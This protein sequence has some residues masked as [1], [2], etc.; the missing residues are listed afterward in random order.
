MAERHYP[1]VNHA[2]SCWNLSNHFTHYC[3]SLKKNMMKIDHNFGGFSHLL[4]GYFIE[5]FCSTA[6][7]LVSDDNTRKQLARLILALDYTYSRVL[8]MS[9]VHILGKPLFFRAIPTYGE[10]PYSMINTK[11]L[12][13]TEKC[14]AVPGRKFR[15]S[16]TKCLATNY[17][18]TISRWVIKGGIYYTKR[19]ASYTVMHN[20]TSNL[21]VFLNH[22]FCLNTIEKSIHSTINGSRLF[23]AKISS[24][25]FM[26][27]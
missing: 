25:R 10:V 26:G 11:S 3:A 1:R 4:L 16:A 8:N 21:F 24:N 20:G 17:F 22:R 19:F 6:N 2:R 13:A 18:I 27:S 9:F 14:V 15:I 5:I 12:E 7:S 23:W